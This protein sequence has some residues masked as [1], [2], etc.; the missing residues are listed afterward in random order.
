[1]SSG[2][3][4]CGVTKDAGRSGWRHG[5]LS[6]NVRTYTIAFLIYWAVFWWELELALTSPTVLFLTHM[7]LA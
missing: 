6:K 7:H 4:P 5:E 1:M 2:K 3:F